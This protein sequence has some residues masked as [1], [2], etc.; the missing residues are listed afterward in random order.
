MRCR[1]RVGNFVM[2]MDAGRARLEKHRVRQRQDDTQ[3]IPPYS[4]RSRK[5]A[6]TNDTEVGD[7]KEGGQASRGGLLNSAGELRGADSERSS[8]EDVSMELAEKEN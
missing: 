1:I 4:K 3:E 5:A 7:D 6:D 2:E 8:S